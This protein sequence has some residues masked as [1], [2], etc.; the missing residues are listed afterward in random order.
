[1]YSIL[2]PSLAVLY[3]IPSASQSSSSCVPLVTLPTAITHYLFFNTNYL[4]SSISSETPASEFFLYTKKTKKTPYKTKKAPYK[5]KKKKIPK[6]KKPEKKKLQKKV[7][8]EDTFSDTSS[9]TFFT[10]LPT[11]QLVSRNVLSDHCIDLFFGC[12]KVFFFLFF[13]IKN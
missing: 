13:S 10:F 5:T 8:S 12:F 3:L 4:I 7:Y 11:H 6:K 9:R 1:M 2:N